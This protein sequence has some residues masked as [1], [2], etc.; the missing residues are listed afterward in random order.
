MTTGHADGLQC[1][2]LEVIQSFGFLEKLINIANPL[3]EVCL[4]ASIFCY[5]RN[6]FLNLST[7]TFL[8]E[9]KRV[10]MLLRPSLNVSQNFYLNTSD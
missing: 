4:W 8:D 1:R 7:I 5:F 3:I 2:T 6:L 9:M 10:E